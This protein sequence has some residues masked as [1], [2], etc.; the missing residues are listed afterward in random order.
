MLYLGARN[1]TA[2]ELREVLGYNFGHLSNEAINE[3]FV[4]VLREIEDVDSNKY[5]LNV[6]NKLVAQQNFD[7]L[8]TYKENL[9]KYFETTIDSADF[10]HNSVAATDAINEWVKQQTHDKIVKLLSEPL[11]PLTRL[12]LLNA[13]YFKGI[14]ETKFLKNETREE[15]FFNRGIS[16]FK[17]QMM[18]RNGKFNFTEI[19][20]LDSKLLELPYSG[21]DISLYIVLPNER[22]GLKS[23][24][25]KLTDFA[26]IDKSI[27]QLKEV[28][29]PVTIP[30]FKIET[31]YSLKEQL[32]KIGMKSVFT[33]ANLSGIDGKQDLVVSKVI[34]KA[35]IEVNEEGS[36]AAAATAVIVE[37]GLP[38]HVFH[39]VHPF[40][41]FI[42]DNR[43]GMIIFAGH[44]NK[45]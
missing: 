29:L 3:E 40:F 22:Q 23:L 39:A 31:S 28:E 30:K 27:S 10:A 20:E 8:Q 36:E 34:H 33:D 13:V 12:V 25:S 5:Q 19:P 9:K 1:K 45:L 32:E 26:L 6:A 4:T 15:I 44:L 16:E 24:T 14:W 38:P 11:S 17:T 43:N 35:M 42:R 37:R 2:D 7:I 18:R 21:D 41:F